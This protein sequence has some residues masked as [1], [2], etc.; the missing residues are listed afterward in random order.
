M[1]TSSMVPYSNPAGRNQTSPTSGVA[2]MIPGA[3]VPVASPL[4]PGSAVASNPFVP[5]TPGAVTGGAPGG[6]PAGTVGTTSASGATPNTVAPGG[7]I[8]S[9]SSYSSGENDLQK[10]LID[11]L[12]KGTGGSEYALLSS[13]SGTDSTMLQEYINSLAPQEAKAQANLD[14]SL[15]AGGVSQNS[16]VAA[17]GNANLQAEEFGM[18]SDEAAKLT[19]HSEDLTANILQGQQ[20]LAAKEVASS[21]WD[22]LGSVLG[23]VGSIASDFIGAGGLGMFAKKPSSGG[24]G[25]TVPSGSDSSQGDA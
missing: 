24:G 16:S 19:A 17:L 9:N 4:Q 2:P 18:I 23:D 6:V 13:M 22:V 8:T 10:Q 14:A 21:G 15:G 7:F 12:G 3:S 20:S 25:A 5:I 11:I 1:A